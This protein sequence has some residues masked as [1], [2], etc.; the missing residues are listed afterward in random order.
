EPQHLQVMLTELARALDGR[1]A[2]LGRAIDRAD[3]AGAQLM[4]SLEDASAASPAVAHVVDDL[5]RATP[6]LLAT[7]ESATELSRIVLDRPGSLGRLLDA[8]LQAGDA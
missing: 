5:E 2:T 4:G 1:G 3:D 6:D 8:G 7:L